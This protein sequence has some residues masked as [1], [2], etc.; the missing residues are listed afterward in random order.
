[1]SS[2]ESS[3]HSSS[4]YTALIACHWT[5]PVDSPGRDAS[6]R[7]PERREDSRRVPSVFYSPVRETV[8]CRRGV[9]LPDCADT[10]DSVGRRTY[11]SNV[12]MSE[13]ETDRPANGI[14]RDVPSQAT[15]GRPMTRRETASIHELIRD[16]PVVTSGDRP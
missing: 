6:R 5:S 7:V 14:E 10:P 12:T 4:E 15:T 16:D 2:V 3:S 9:S 1:M 11:R 13:A 8:S